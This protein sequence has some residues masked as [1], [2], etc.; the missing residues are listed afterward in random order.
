VA[1]TFGTDPAET[2]TTGKLLTNRP[3]K[4]EHT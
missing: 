3:I 4:V 2:V 1:P